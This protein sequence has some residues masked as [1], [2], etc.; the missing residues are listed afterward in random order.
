[1]CGPQRAG[2]TTERGSSRNVVGQSERASE[3][4]RECRRKGGL[5]GGSFSGSLSFV[6]PPYTLH[7]EYQILNNKGLA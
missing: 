2:P 7:R 4:E 3:R 6:S 5:A 1:M